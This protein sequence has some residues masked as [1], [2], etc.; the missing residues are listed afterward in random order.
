MSVANLVTD[1]TTAG[2]NYLL[3]IASYTS[4]LMSIITGGGSVVTI[5]ML[6]MLKR[7]DGAS[8]YNGLYAM[9]EAALLNVL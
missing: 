1:T 7:K 4:A 6:D 8:G 2:D 3:M 5:S 9:P